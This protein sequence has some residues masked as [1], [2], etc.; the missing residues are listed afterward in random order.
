MNKRDNY[1]DDPELF[2]HAFTLFPQT[3]LALR[4]SARQW[5]LSLSCRCCTVCPM[6]YLPRIPELCCLSQLCP[7]AAVHLIYISP[8]HPILQTCSLAST[9]FVWTRESTRWKLWVTVTLP[10]P[11]C[12][13]RATTTP[14][15]SSALQRQSWWLP[16]RCGIRPPGATSS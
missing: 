5:S 3:L 13:S 9:P 4:A 2:I 1:M 10:A 14:S 7:D 12:W 8:D 15:S 6:G 16:G 11:G